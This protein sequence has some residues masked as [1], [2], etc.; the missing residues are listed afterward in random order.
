SEKYHTTVNSALGETDNREI[1]DKLKKMK[2]MVNEKKMMEDWESWMQQK[3]AILVRRNIR[4][5]NL[6]LHQEINT[7]SL[8]KDESLAKNTNLGISE[9]DQEDQ[10]EEDMFWPKSEISPFREWARP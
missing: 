9:K 5:T 8:N 4:S 3:T 10:E 2:K 7:L 6:N 1:L